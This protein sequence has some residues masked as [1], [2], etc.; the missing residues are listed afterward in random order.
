M[1]TTQIE[2]AG[3]VQVERGGLAN[4]RSHRARVEEPTID[5]Q[6]TDTGARLNASAGDLDAC[7]IVRLTCPTRPRRFPIGNSG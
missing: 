3:R 6:D 2:S 7:R 4:G 5:F 1:R